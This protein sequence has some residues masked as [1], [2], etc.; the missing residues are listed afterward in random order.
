MEL[1][2]LWGLLILGNLINITYQINKDLKSDETDWNVLADWFKNVKNTMYCVIG[3]LTSVAI[4]T[5]IDYQEIGTFEIG[6]LKFFWSH[7]CAVFVGALGQFIW[8]KALLRAKRE[9]NENL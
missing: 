7:V 9:I 8:A 3:L 1:L 4:M 6:P 2:T 5:F